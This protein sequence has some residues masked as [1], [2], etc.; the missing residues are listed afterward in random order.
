MSELRGFT[1]P[2]WGIEMTEGVITQWHV[3]ENQSFTSGQTLLSVETDKIVN[4]IEAE[5]EA[6]CLRMIG[7][8]DETYPVGALLAVMGP[9]GTAKAEVDAFI[10]GF[11]PVAPVAEDEEDETAPAPVTTQATPAPV[12]YTP[13]TDKAVSPAAAV[14]A[15]EANADL[16]ALTGSG[17]AGRILKQDVE[18][19]IRP[20][21]NRPSD[22]VDISVNAGDFAD[23][24]A[25]PVARHHAATHNLDLASVKGSGKACRVRL[26]DLPGVQ[27]DGEITPFGAVK[28]RIAAKLTAAARDIPQ[29]HLEIEIN[30]LAMKAQREAL[31]KQVSLN[32]LLVK[33]VA[34][35][36]VNH[37][38]VNVHVSDEG[39]RSFSEANVAVAVA[40]DSGLMT[41]VI[42]KANTLSIQDLA[43][44]SRRLVEGTRAGS[45]KR[46]DYADGTFTVSNLGMYGI[47]RF[48]SIINPPQGGI[49]SVG[50]LR[51]QLAMVDGQVVRHEVIT[52]TMACDHRAIDGATGA[53]FLKDLKARL[54][55]GE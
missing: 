7:L 54:E 53:S 1:M 39:T 18:Q 46:E 25:T 8:S 47:T 49:L 24:A 35:T 51:A 27:R 42:A 10:D 23:A 55:Q 15:A 32:D 28:S 3:E 9:E 6:T 40:V 50:T 48:T 45:L 34:D 29:F 11:V 4:D 5:Y 33:G 21:V 31:N 13:N 16:S 43:A 12:A 17:S 26:S 36:L 22:P 14:V 19:M 44:E 41:P 37:P 38:A 20:G 2:K 30:A 52:L